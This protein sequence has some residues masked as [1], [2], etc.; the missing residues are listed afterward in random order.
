MKLPL[1]TKTIFSD[2]ARADDGTAPAVSCPRRH[3]QGGMA[4]I[5]MLALLSIML[6]F[7]AA[8]IH[9]L[10]SLKREVQLTEKRQTQ[11]L[12]TLSATN[13]AAASP[14]VMGPNANPTN[15]PA[16]PQPSPK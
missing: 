6:L 9:A 10:Y 16:R 5:V 12:A 2:R 4:V 13:S 1:I 14:N 3:R 15:K 8:N 7:I 11:R